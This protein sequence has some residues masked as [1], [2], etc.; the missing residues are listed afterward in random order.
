M[1]HLE[2]LTDGQLRYLVQAILQLLHERALPTADDSTL[3][4]LYERGQL[5]GE[6]L[7]Q[8]LARI[9]PPEGSGFWS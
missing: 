6:S 1:V 9:A 8:F 7:E 5:P 4:Q 2:T 3:A